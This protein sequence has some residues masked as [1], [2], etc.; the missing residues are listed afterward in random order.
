MWPHQFLQLPLI[1][2]YDIKLL[3]TVWRRAARSAFDSRCSPL[4]FFWFGHF[5][6][7]IFTKFCAFQAH[8]ACFLSAQNRMSA[9]YRISR[10]R[11]RKKLLTRQKP[12]IKKE[13]KKTQTHFTGFTGGA[14]ADNAISQAKGAAQIGSL[15][16]IDRVARGVNGRPRRER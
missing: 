6:N 16:P 15:W 7:T 11:W 13:N 10:R 12:Q 3:K 5:W 1:V 8:C 9:S 4:P 2:G 14:N